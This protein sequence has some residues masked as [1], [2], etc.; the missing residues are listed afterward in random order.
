MHWEITEGDGTR[1]IAG[2]DYGGEG[3][4]ILLHHANGFCAGTWGLVAGHLTKRH[5]VYAMDARGHGDSDACRVPEEAEWPSF[6][7]DAAQVARL[8]AEA[9]GESR[10]AMAVGSSFG[11]IVCA[12]AEA[13]HGPCFERIVMLDPPIHPNAQMCAALG[14]PAPPEGPTRQNE[15]VEMTLRRRSEWPSRE[16][17]VESW[18]GKAMF[19]DW[20]PGGFELYLDHGFKDL[21]DG[22]VALKCDPQVEANIFATTGVMDPLD[23]LPRVTVPVQLVRAVHGFFPEDLF[24]ALAD[25]LPNGTYLEIDAGH[26]LPLE[27]PEQ[28]VEVVLT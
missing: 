10:L 4:P 12:C 28:C 25:V 22:S 2:L 13:Y 6:V 18:Q 9:H 11:G 14:L 15:L 1:R 20:Q 17:L 3:R 23:F 27:A 24:R 21:P 5:R 19:A 8:I 26:L 16:A 7:S